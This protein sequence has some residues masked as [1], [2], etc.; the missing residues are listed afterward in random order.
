MPYFRSNSVYNSPIASQ[1]YN[2]SGLRTSPVVTNTSNLN[3]YTN[4]G[5]VGTGYQT[6]NGPQQPSIFGK[7]DGSH[8]MTHTTYTTGD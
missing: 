6:Y 1:N 3:T 7:K 2:A 8:V 4:Y 5:T